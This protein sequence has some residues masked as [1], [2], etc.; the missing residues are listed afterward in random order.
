[1]H[2]STLLHKQVKY[3]E[4]LLRKK[5]AC[6]EVTLKR[7]QG[8]KIIMTHPKINEKCRLEWV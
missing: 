3:S 5:K 6:E 8:I 2:L 7:K 4:Q 1:M